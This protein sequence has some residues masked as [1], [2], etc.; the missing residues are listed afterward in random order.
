MRITATLNTCIFYYFYKI[1]K[2]YYFTF[3]LLRMYYNSTIFPDRNLKINIFVCGLSM[4]STEFIS[5]RK[6][7]WRDVK[8]QIKPMRA[9]KSDVVNHNSNLTFYRFSTFSVGFQTKRRAFGFWSYDLTEGAIWSIALKR[10]A[11]KNCDAQM[12][13]EATE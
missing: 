8:K 1:N 2:C 4:K 7:L 6:K 12:P 9:Q 11:L 5:P 10:I 3:Y 13:W